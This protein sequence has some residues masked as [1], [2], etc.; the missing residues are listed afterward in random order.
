[1]SLKDTFARGTAYDKKSKQWNDITNAITIH[2]AKDMV[3]LSIVEKDGFKEM[4]KTLDPRY[5]LPSRNYFSRTAIP[6]LYQKHRAKLE[7]D[8]AT[9]RHFSATTDLWS[10]RS[11][12]PYLSLT[13][14]FISDDWVLRSHCL[15]TSYFPEDHTV[16]LLAAGLQEALDSWG[17]SE[18]RLVAI[19]T[20]SGTNIIKAVELNNW[21]RLQCFGHRLHLAIGKYQLLY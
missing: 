19:T 18:H 5:V 11:M 20:D 7:A 1:M 14:H 4:I 13:V 8:L 21:T 15:Q 9:V 6:N 17:F 16:E 2:L 3:P 10:S 12:E